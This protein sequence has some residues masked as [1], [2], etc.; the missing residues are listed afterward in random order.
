MGPPHRQPQPQ[1]ARR[2]SPLAC[3]F[4][5]GVLVAT[6]LIGPLALHI[7]Y[8][9]GLHATKKQYS[10]S[11]ATS[12]DWGRTLHHAPT[13]AYRSIAVVTRPEIVTDAVTQ[14]AIAHTPAVE[15]PATTLPVAA[16]TALTKAVA[17][18]AEATTPATAATLK[19]GKAWNE[20]TRAELIDTLA[21]VMA[22]QPRAAPNPSCSVPPTPKPPECTELGFAGKRKPGDVAT[23]FRVMPFGYEADTLEIALREYQ[24]LN[25]KAVLIE[26]ALSH[27]E[28]FQH[29]NSQWDRIKDQPR[30][31]GLRDMV[32]LRSTMPADFI[33]RFS[34][35]AMWA[36][37][38]AQERYGLDEAKKVLANVMK[39]TDVLVMGSPDE[40]MSRHI[41]HSLSHC[42]LKDPMVGAAV[43]FP[44]GFVERAFRPD[45]RPHGLTYSFTLPTA[46]SLG[47]FAYEKIIRYFDPPNKAIYLQGGMHLTGYTLLAAA[48][49]KDVSTT[50]H[51]GAT[52]RIAQLCQTGPAALRQTLRNKYL[53]SSER[54]TDVAGLQDHEKK[55]YVI[56]W[57]LNCNRERYPSWFKDAAT[58]DSRD[59]DVYRLLCPKG[60]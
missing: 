7:G 3:G 29:K 39:P 48:L 1:P 47:R 6:V 40:I 22:Q 57:F 15:G 59:D 58:P 2:S 60:K 23:V 25:V 4:L 20:M 5:T 14:A 31:D 17:T 19:V 38:R 37:E 9:Q 45:F 41:M 36:S 30:F 33:R 12:A 52:T 10:G 34:Q 32:I 56:P 55:S 16:T 11:V 43:G 8:T 24:G 51:D 44:H 54:V 53:G 27:K 13:S 26:S 21:Q 35:D 42:E 49:I 50:D 18:T 28:P 46:Y